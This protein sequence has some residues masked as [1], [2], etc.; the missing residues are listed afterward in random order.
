MTRQ[1]QVLSAWEPEGQKEA[2]SGIPSA[3]GSRWVGRKNE[4]GREL[5]NEGDDGRVSR[6][7]EIERMGFIRKMTEKL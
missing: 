3:V 4:K 7:K 1:A 6:L 2:E 5:A